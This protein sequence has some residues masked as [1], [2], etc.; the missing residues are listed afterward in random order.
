VGG[1]YAS[2]GPSLVAEVF[3]ID[4]HL[5]GGL[6]I[7]ALNGTGILGSIALRTSRPERALL[8]GALLFTVGSVGTIGALFTTSAPLLFASSI[9]SGFAFGA[10]FL[11]AVATITAGVAPH[12]RAGLMA[13]IFVV[14]YLAFSVPSIVAGTAIGTFGLVRTTEVYAAV[15]VLLALLAVAALLRARKRLA[16]QVGGREPAVPEVLAA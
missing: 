6:L 8:V 11:G 14:G 16:R 5:V 15:V 4:N 12:H 2:L 9:V 10:A 3:D 7:L 1:L 13:S